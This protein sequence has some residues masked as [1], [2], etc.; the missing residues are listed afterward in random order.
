MWLLLMAVRVFF[1]DGWSLPQSHS[2]H[3]RTAQEGMAKM[4]EEFKKQGAEIYL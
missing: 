3:C 2:E 4:S 1:G